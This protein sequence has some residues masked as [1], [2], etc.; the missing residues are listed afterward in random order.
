MSRNRFGDVERIGRESRDTAT[1]AF[2]DVAWV[3]VSI[4]YAELMV[5]AR[6]QINGFGLVC[7][8]E[9]SLNEG[10]FGEVL[11]HG[12]EIGVIDIGRRDDGDE[13]ERFG[14]LTCSRSAVSLF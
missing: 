10:F 13:G 1:V 14:R 6:E 4:R 2:A 12:G 5:F 7:Q 9:V 11:G 8:F 3:A